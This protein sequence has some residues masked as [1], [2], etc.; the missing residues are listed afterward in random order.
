[1]PGVPAGAAEVAPTATSNVAVLV[2]DSDSRDQ[3][4]GG[5]IRPE[6]GVG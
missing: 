4:G 6:G 5:A 2:G 3:W 1:M